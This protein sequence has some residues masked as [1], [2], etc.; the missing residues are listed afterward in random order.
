M[1][2]GVTDPD[3]Y[4]FSQQLIDHW[5]DLGHEVMVSL[6]HEPAFVEKCDVIYYEY[7]TNMVQQ[8]AKEGKKPKRVIVRAI[9]VENYMGYHHTFNYDFIDA[10]IFLNKSHKKMVIENGFACPKE[11]IHVIPPGIN[12]SKYTLRETDPEEVLKIAYVGRLWIGKAVF[13]ALDVAEAW[14]HLGQPVKLYLRGDGFDPPWYK[15]YVE[16]RIETSP[17]EVV[18]DG[19][20]DN[21]NTYL[22]DKDVLIVPSF[23]E[24]FSYVAAEAMAKGIPTLIN[25]WYGAREVWPEWMI[26]RQPM[27]AFSKYGQMAHRPRKELRAVIEERYDEQLMFGRIDALLQE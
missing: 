12:L 11:K 14:W 27:D 20:V 21:L 4:K 22:E 23:K 15:K 6:Y 13:G 7:A 1:I 2:V 10:F 9:D 19:W 16:Y 8:L 25:D 17:V 3:Q 24:A 5:R 18:F 26:Y